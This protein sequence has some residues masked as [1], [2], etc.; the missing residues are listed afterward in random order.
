MARPREYDEGSR[1][2]L[3]TRFDRDVMALFDEIAKRQHLNRTQALEWCVSDAI[4][5]Q[6]I[7][8]FAQEINLLLEARRA[9]R[10]LGEKKSI[11]VPGK[12]GAEGAVPTRIRKGRQTPVNESPQ[13]R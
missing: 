12:P 11:L 9:Q 6:R 10:L 3:G 8:P 4:K 2:H 13:V 1:V 5:N 7:P